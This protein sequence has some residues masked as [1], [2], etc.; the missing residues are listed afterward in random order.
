[1]PVRAAHRQP[2]GPADR[3]PALLEDAVS[4]AALHLTIALLLALSAAVNRPGFVR[5]FCSGMA[6]GHVLWGVLLLVA[7]LA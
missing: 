5:G 3:L 4:P 2:A 6:L 1:V 7:V